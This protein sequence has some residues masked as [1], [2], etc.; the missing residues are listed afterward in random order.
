VSTG[1]KCI[2]KRHAA[3]RVPAVTSQP[4]LVITRQ[5]VDSA[6]HKNKTELGIL[7]FAVEVQVL[8]HRDS[9]LDQLVQVLRNFW[10]QTCEPT[11][12]GVHQLGKQASKTAKHGVQKLQHS[13][14]PNVL[15]THHAVKG[16]PPSRRGNL[17]FFFNRRRMV[18]VVT[19]RTCAM[20]LESRNTT[21]ICDGVMPFFACLQIIS[22]TCNASASLL[23]PS[24]HCD[25]PNATVFLYQGLHTRLTGRET[26]S[27]HTHASAAVVFSQDGGLRL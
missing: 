8:P 1:G 25:V 20:P 18:W 10:R 27:L 17:P 11:R 21:P 13:K 26:L 22:S 14:P 19:A 24:C 9:L 16:K 5:P 2:F 15:L 23:S 4:D 3:A 7:V 12:S 6:L